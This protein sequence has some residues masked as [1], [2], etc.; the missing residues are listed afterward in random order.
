MHLILESDYCIF[1]SMELAPKTRKGCYTFLL[2][3][4]VRVPGST[5]QLKAISKDKSSGPWSQEDLYV[6]ACC[7]VEGRYIG[8][9]LSRAFNERPKFWYLEHK[10]SC[11]T[12]QSRQHLRQEIDSQHFVFGHFFR[13]IRMMLTFSLNRCWVPPAVRILLKILVFDDW[14]KYDLLLTLHITI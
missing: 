12:Q 4:F 13:F 11:R 2:V 8:G 7:A 6:G 5:W 3:D 14:G 1:F 9:L 10:T